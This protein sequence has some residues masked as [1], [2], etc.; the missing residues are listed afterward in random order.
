MT[1]V[2]YPL[3]TSHFALHIVLV[4]FNILQFYEQWQMKS[5]NDAYDFIM[6]IINNENDKEAQEEI[7]KSC[8]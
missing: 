1:Q 4:M 2:T 7:D 5:F 8:M 6:R 3:V